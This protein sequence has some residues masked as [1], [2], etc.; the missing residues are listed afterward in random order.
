MNIA[1]AIAKVII[2]TNYE[3]FIF[4]ASKTINKQGDWQE[5]PCY[6]CKLPAYKHL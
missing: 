6:F 3:E 5:W 4:T 2:S 1:K